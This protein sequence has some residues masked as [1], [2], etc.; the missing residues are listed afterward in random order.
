MDL[1][2]TALVLPHTNSSKQLGLCTRSK[3]SALVSLMHSWGY[4]QGGTGCVLAR[5]N[6]P[7]WYLQGS[8][9]WR[10]ELSLLPVWQPEVT[11]TYSSVCHGSLLHGAVA[12][13]ILLTLSP[14]QLTSLAMSMCCTSHSIAGPLQAMLC[15]CVSGTPPA[16]GHKAAGLLD[17]TAWQGSR[18][19]GDTSTVEA[20]PAGQ[21]YCHTYNTLR[22][23]PPTG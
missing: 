10:I 2:A 17:T 21:K 11:V 4:L 19:Q 23:V 16:W 12:V 20:G 3:A 18:S 5:R 8:D 7:P 22:P 15:N 1:A 13:L 14:R 9:Q 6:P